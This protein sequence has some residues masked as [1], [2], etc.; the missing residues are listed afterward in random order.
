MWTSYLA[1]DPRDGKAYLER[2]GA[3]FQLGRRDERVRTQRP[4]C[5]LGVSEA[6]HAK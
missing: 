1:A 6:A 5:E 4:A 2:G 3:L